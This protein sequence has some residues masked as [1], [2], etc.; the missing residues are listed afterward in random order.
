MENQISY[1]A[2]APSMPP[3]PSE[4][5]PRKKKTFLAIIIFAI[6]LLIISGGVFGYFYYSRSPEKIVQK[7]IGR[8]AEIKSLEYSGELKAEIDRNLSG[9]SGKQSSDFSVIFNGASDVYDLN[10]PKSSFSLDIKTDALGQEESSLKTEIRNIGEVVYIKLNDIPDLGFFDLSFLKE[11][12][13]KIDA[14]SL[15]RQLGLEEKLNEE[16]KAQNLSPEQIE[17]IKSSFERNGIFKITQK[18]ADEKINGVNAYHYKFAV[19]KEGVKEI[20]IDAVKIVQNKTPNENEIEGLN[21]GLEL[22]EFPENE[23]WIGKKDLLPYKISLN[24]TIKETKESKYSSNFSLVLSFKNFNKPVQVDAP[25]EVKTLE[26]I[27]MGVFGG[28]KF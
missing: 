7:M 17:K 19:N 12:W 18:L 28:L 1:P 20:I 13:I 15:K 10:N 11:Q 8:L 3:I 6:G 4:Q 9:N 16:Q 14:D 23:I 24:S 26:E 25:K 22:I 21:K 2:A 5:P 27:L